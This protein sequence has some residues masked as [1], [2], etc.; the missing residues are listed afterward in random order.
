MDINVTPTVATCVVS[1]LLLAVPHYD[2]PNISS[3]FA[4]VDAKGA[5]LNVTVTFRGTHSDGPYEVTAPAAPGGLRLQ[6]DGA[7]TIDG[8]LARRLLK[9]HGGRLHADSITFRAGYVNATFENRAKSPVFADCATSLWT[10]CTSESG[11]PAGGVAP[12]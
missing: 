1:R 8:G 11:Q 5:G 2:C 10:R 3:A 12:A 6:G 9:V 4:L 7:A